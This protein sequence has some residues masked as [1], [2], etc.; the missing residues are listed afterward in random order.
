MALSRLIW[1]PELGMSG[2]PINISYEG[3][4][5]C[6]FALNSKG[7]DT[8]R[9][10]ASPAQQCPPCRV[11]AAL[12][13]LGTLGAKGNCAVSTLWPPFPCYGSDLSIRGVGIVSS[14]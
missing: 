10:Q 7:F 3:H 12:C 5:V 2:L 13:P 14:L 9:I 6:R 1:T 11:A 4:R 8:G